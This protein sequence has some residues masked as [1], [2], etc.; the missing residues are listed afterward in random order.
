MGTGDGNLDYTLNQTLCKA[1][2]CRPQNF[3]QFAGAAHAQIEM[4]RQTP[5]KCRRELR[6]RRRSEGGHLDRGLKCCNLFCCRIVAV[7]TPSLAQC[8]EI[9]CCPIAQNVATV[10]AS[11]AAAAAV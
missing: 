11:T 8:R 6:R 3:Q 10:F 1:A 9:S 2:A 4:T 7:F 5:T